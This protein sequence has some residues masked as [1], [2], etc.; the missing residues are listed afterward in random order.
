MPDGHIGAFSQNGTGDCFFL[1]TLL[2]L[3]QDP[4]GKRLLES[5]IH[6]PEASTRWS[7]VFPNLPDYKINITQKEINEYKLKNAAS[8][9]LSLSARGDPDVALLEI[10]AD[11]IW[12]RHFKPEGLWDDVPM[13][14]LFMFSAAKQ[15]LIWNRSK[16]SQPNIRDIE[17][18]RHIP[19]DI[20]SEVNVTSS[21]D[22][23]NKLKN[24][25]AADSDGI[26]MILIDYINY[27]AVAITLL[28]FTQKR[29]SYIDT[30]ASTELS[31]DLS[32]LLRGLARGIY[33]VNY[34]EVEP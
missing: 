20:V 17:K 28:D 29:Y 14:A 5:A 11:K 24:I 7:I 32:E 21:S 18:F 19:E 27:H 8:N 12:R 13:N 1:A 26:S 15:S 4:D 30:Y 3:A 34:M 10:A 9:G 25:I 16:A 33:A 31:G 2:A 6:K 22:A 23:E